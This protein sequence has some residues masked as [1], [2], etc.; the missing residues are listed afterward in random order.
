ML[1]QIGQAAAYR[2]RGKAGGREERTDRIDKRH[3]NRER[4]VASELL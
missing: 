1:R 3:T 2:G 4:D